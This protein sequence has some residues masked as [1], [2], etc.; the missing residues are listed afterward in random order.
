MTQLIILNSSLTVSVT[1]QNWTPDNIGSLY[2]TLI[3]K[4]FSVSQLTSAQQLQ[5]QFVPHARKGTTT[6][7]TVD[8][9][10]RRLIFQITNEINSPNKN[11]EEILEVLKEVGFPSQ[12][13]IERV[14]IQGKITIKMQEG[15]ASKLIPRIIKDEFSTV[16]DEI[17]GRKTNVIGTSKAD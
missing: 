16:A 1:L 11:I 4:G 13:S 14:D 6:A 8:Q 17:M 5:G 12:E 10:T 15:N 2:D 3:K 9:A 7:F